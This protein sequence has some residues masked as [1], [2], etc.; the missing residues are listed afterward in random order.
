MREI[1]TSDLKLNMV[2]GQDVYNSA[3]Q[4]IIPMG[5]ILTKYAIDRLEQYS[6]RRVYIIEE[7]PKK[8]SFI[9][10]TPKFTETKKFKEFK[11]EYDEG[12]HSIQDSLNDIVEKNAPVDI[13]NMYNNMESLINESDSINVMD[14][15]A[16]LRH[17]D[18]ST[19][20]HAVNVSLIC[21]MLARWLNFSEEDIKMVTMCG[22]LHDVGKIKIPS[23]IIKKPGK[24]T[25]EEY[26]IVKRHSLEGYKILN[27]QKVDIQIQYAALMHHERCDGSGY[28]RGLHREQISPFAKIVAIADVYDAMTANRV[29]R[30]P[31]CPFE[32]IRIFE[33]E[34]LRK[35]ETE[36]IMTF[37][38]RVADT[39]MNAEVKLTDGREGKVVFINK[40]Q[41]HAPT[42]QC[43]GDIV[44]LSRQ[45]ELK[46]VQI[47]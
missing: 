23:E 18:D 42:I 31:I 37:L 20:A 13:D 46:V 12:I 21:N 22:L 38:Q 5:T 45:R 6:I 26:T 7:T 29:Y 1:R 28:P 43:G 2:I 35:Y 41:I 10:E 34:G 44:D 9:E 8:E 15:I 33:N 17:Y 36:Y 3:S 14:M 27:G 40:M 30:G 24:L 25:E 39:Y 19:Y 16:N 4:L 47:L 11:K 32:V